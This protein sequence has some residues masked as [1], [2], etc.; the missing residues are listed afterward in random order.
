[1]KYGVNDFFNLA[2]SAEEFYVRLRLNLL[3]AERYKEIEKISQTDA[4]TGLFNRRYFFEHCEHVYSNNRF[5]YHFIVML[6]IDLFK[7]INDDFGHQRGDQA[8]QF[9]AEKLKQIF[10]KYLVARFGGEEF[11]VCGSAQSQ[12]EVVRLCEQ[13]RASISM[14]SKAEISVEFS[15]SIGVCFNVEDVEKALLLADEALYEAKATG[16]NKVVVI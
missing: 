16:R 4:M 12:E 15:T 3:Q 1:M 14:Q 2:A 11:C 9:M 10:G 13:L 8:I 6:D 5:E 7:R